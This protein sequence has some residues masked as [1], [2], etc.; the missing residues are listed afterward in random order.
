[1][2][3]CVFGGFR[4]WFDAIRFYCFVNEFNAI[5]SIKAISVYSRV[6]VY[7]LIMPI[8]RRFD[9]NA[10]FAA[11]IKLPR[12]DLFCLICPA[13]IE[14]HHFYSNALRFIPG[15]INVFM[16]FDACVRACAIV[17][18]VKWKI[19]HFYVYCFRL[20]MTKWEMEMFSSHMNVRAVLVAHCHSVLDTPYCVWVCISFSFGVGKCF[21]CW[22]TLAAAATAAAAY[23]SHVCVHMSMCYACVCTHIYPSMR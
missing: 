17:G 15:V 8:D 5:F 12:G 18:Y 14:V 16:G 4:N 9:C 11:R 10:T 19:V 22:Y 13:L 21:M 2:D 20:I 3:W 7:T 1:M 6:C 23:S